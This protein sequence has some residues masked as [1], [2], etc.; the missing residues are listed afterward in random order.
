MITINDVPTKTP[1]PIVEMSRS[2]ACDREKESGREPARN[3][4]VRANSAGAS[5]SLGKNTI[6]S[7]NRHHGAQG[8]QREQAV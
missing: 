6:D 1:M 5:L 8:E 7:R 4:L 3:D 2:C